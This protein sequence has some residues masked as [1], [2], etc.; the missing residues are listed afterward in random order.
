M[1]KRID[2]V[3]LHVAKIESDR[4]FRDEVEAEG[5]AAVF[6]RR[7]AKCER[8]GARGRGLRSRSI[9]RTGP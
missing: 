1:F 8:Q 4:R 5:P 3:A 6:K 9:F 7:N 2:H